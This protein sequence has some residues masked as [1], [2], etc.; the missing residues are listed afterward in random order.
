MGE[1]THGPGNAR[2]RRTR[3]ALLAAARTLLEEQ[4]FEALTMA[5]VAERAGITRRAVY[6]HFRSRSEL[7]T[8][9]FT[10][11]VADE[12]LAES[13]RPV[14]EA[15]DA[16]STLEEFARH[17]ARFTPRLRTVYHAVDRVR[18]QD[19]DAAAHRA[20]TDRN[21]R[22]GAQEV[23]RRLDTEGR[24][25][26]PWTE[27]TATDMLWALMSVD[28]LERLMVDRGWSREQFGERMAALLR[29]TLVTPGG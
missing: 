20:L 4:G 8:D 1:P 9:L 25:A 23:I 10:H 21:Q 28:L 14:W 3:D 17:L 2:G 5:A 26:P 7:V 24:L 27:E 29:A 13:L 19:P 16:V 22:A 6:Q 11:A 18:H 15:P 12:G